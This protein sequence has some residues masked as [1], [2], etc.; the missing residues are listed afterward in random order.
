MVTPC[1]LSVRAILCNIAKPHDGS[2]PY[3]DLPVLWYEQASDALEQ[4]AFPRP[5]APDNPYGFTRESFK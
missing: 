5:I 2:F 4:R 3:C 1:A